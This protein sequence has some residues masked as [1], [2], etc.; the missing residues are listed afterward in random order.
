MSIHANFR[1]NLKELKKAYTRTLPAG[2]VVKTWRGART[3]GARRA[4]WGRAWRVDVGRT[5]IAAQR[6]SLCQLFLFPAIHSSP[7]LS[8]KQKL[9]LVREFGAMQIT[10]VLG[11]LVITNS[12]F[13]MCQG[14]NTNA[15]GDFDFWNRISEE[16]LAEWELEAMLAVLLERQRSSRRRFSICLAYSEASVI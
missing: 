16:R 9:Y 6:G 5:E 13:G 12:C 2:Q 3:W 1:D 14:S 8:A 10:A 4:A 7:K 15:G 11:L